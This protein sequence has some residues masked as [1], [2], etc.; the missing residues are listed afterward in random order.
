MFPLVTCELPIDRIPE[1]IVTQ[2][3]CDGM[4][5]QGHG[6]L[7]NMGKVGTQQ[8]PKSRNQQILL[9]PY[10]EAAMLYCVNEE[11]YIIT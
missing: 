4:Q 6:H 2:G 8:A 9:N 5:N 11:G 10:E 1:D 7:A 3:Q